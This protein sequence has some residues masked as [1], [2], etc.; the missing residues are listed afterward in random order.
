MLPHQA[1]LYK[2]FEALD[3]ADL[4]TA[5][6]QIDLF[7]AALENDPIARDYR[8]QIFDRQVFEADFLSLFTKE[9][10]DAWG[11][12]AAIKMQRGDWQGA[13]FDCYKQIDLIDQHYGFATHSWERPESRIPRDQEL[14]DRYFR[15]ASNLATIMSELDEPDMST[16][17][18]KISN[19]AITEPVDPDEV[20]GRWIAEGTDPLEPLGLS[21]YELQDWS[22]EKIDIDGTNCLVNLFSILPAHA[23]PLKFNTLVKVCIP[24]EAAYDVPAKSVRWRIWS[25]RQAI[26]SRFRKH[27]VGILFG[28]LQRRGE[29]VLLYYVKDEKEARQIIEPV[30]E[31]AIDLEPRLEINGDANW[32]EYSKAGGQS[33][34]IAPPLVQAPNV[35]Q[36]GHENDVFLQEI[37]NQCESLTSAWSKMYSLLWVVNLVSPKSATM[38]KYCV[39]YFFELLKS[40]SDQEKDSA[41]WHMAWKL[42]SFD[43]AAAVRALDMIELST[44]PSQNQ[45]TANFAAEALA[46]F[47]PERALK[48]IDVLKNEGY[49]LIHRAAGKTAVTMA[50]TDVQRGRM[51]IIATRDYILGSTDPAFSK[52]TQLTELAHAV[53][54]SYP[55]EARHLL[56]EAHND[57]KLVDRRSTCAQVYMALLEATKNAAP[58][59]LPDFCPGAIHAAFE[60]MAPSDSWMDFGGPALAINYICWIVPYMV[61]YNEPM[62]LEVLMQAIDTVV[63][64]DD[65]EL[66]DTLPSLAEAAGTLD[67]NLNRE[68]ANRLW[69][70]LELRSQVFRSPGRSFLENRCHAGKPTPVEAFVRMN[71]DVAAQRIASIL[72]ICALSPL[73]EQQ[74]DLLSTCAASMPEHPETASSLIAK[75]TDSCRKPSSAYLRAKT[76]AQVAASMHSLG[77]NAA[78]LCAETM[79][80]IDCIEVP[81]TRLETILD[82]SKECSDNYPELASQL[83]E[84]AAAIIQ[85]VEDVPDTFIERLY[86]LPRGQSSKLFFELLKRR[87]DDRKLSEYVSRFARSFADDEALTDHSGK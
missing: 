34:V 70:L 69:T 28:E 17:W 84:K 87:K 36:H 73:P 49:I 42:P 66:L 85:E 41:I 20:W 35:G 40:L 72:A 11:V 65:E 63:E 31:A 5:E 33:I 13:R 9:E 61:L 80:I 59:L 78:P 76:F 43:A 29:R 38:Q 55:E 81:E 30:L 22:L 10:I 24:T 18:S 51:L 46:D 48:I 67:T 57:I 50:R 74:A 3:S 19:A 26:A 14:A 32:Q 16:R 12:L 2:A 45:C 62:A 6:A 44:I 1:P 64:L 47:A 21:P 39:D 71:Q 54:R 8:T 58:A 83:L 79:T 7:F 27:N 23:S 25:L 86:G 77:L 15:L 75:A 68:L 37:W 56:V 82:A 4:K 52:I 53:Y 60:L